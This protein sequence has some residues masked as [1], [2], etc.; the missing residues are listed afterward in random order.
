MSA[1][2]LVAGEVEPVRATGSSTA[3]ATHLRLRLERGCSAHYGSKK[4]TTSRN[5]DEHIA[6]EPPSAWR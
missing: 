1:D 5:V 6:G 4:P 2:A 3:A